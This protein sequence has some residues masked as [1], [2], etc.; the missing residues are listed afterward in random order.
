MFHLVSRW[1]SKRTLNRGKGRSQR[2]PHR[3]T[4][5]QL[6]KRD[7]L[8]AFTAG[9]LIV[10]RVGTGTGALGGNATTTFID[11]YTPAGA[12]VQSIS[13]PSTST[14]A[15]I[16]DASETGTTVTI[17]ANNSFVP[18]QAVVIAG[19][20][21]N[22][23]NGTFTITSVAANGSSFT[24]TA[25]PGLGTAMDVTSATATVSTDSL[26]E[27]GNGTTEGLLGL[28]P[29]RHSVSLAG[30]NQVP[31]GSTST[32]FAVNRVV[33]WITPDG[34]ID[35]STQLP[36]SAGS[37]RNAISATGLGFYIATSTGVLF[38]PYG[39]SGSTAP[40]LL[41][42]E[43]ASP[44]AVGIF[45]SYLTSP[46]GGWLYGSAG[47][48][49]QS[50]GVP[51]VDSP[52]IVSGSN[53]LP[54]V[55]G[56][57]I[58]NPPTS[59]PT[60]R[61]SMGNF[62]T[63]IQF[64]VSPDGNTIFI[65]DSRTDGLGGIIE[66]YQLVPGTFIRPGNF[67]IGTGA[68]S[69]LLGL[70][71]DFSNPSSPVLYAT[72]TASSGNRL[73][74]ITGGTTDGSTPTFV[75]T[76]LATAPAN[77]AIRGVSLAP[78]PA[79]ST[80][81]ATALSVGSGTGT[82]GAG[83]T[84][85]ATVTGGAGTPTGWVSFQ[86]NGVEIGAAPLNASGTATF[87]TAGNLGAAS[88]PYDVA[89][90]YTG[91]ATYA[92]SPST[93]HSVTINQA[94]ATTALTFS[95]NPVATGVNDTL[96]ATITAPVGT[97]PTGT[98]SFFDGSTLLN[99]TP[100]PVTQV[101]TNDT[102]TF[103]ASFT[104]SFSTTGSHMIRA[105]YSGDTNFTTSNDTHTLQVVNATTTT[106][107]TDNADP[108]ANPSTSFTLTAT[109]TSLGAGT[110]T[111]MV[112]FYDNLRPIGGPITVSGPSNTGAVGTVTVSTALL[113]ATGVLTPGLH[114]ISAIYTPDATSAMSY[115]TST[116][117]YEQFVQAQSFAAND[118]FVYRV[119]DGATNLIAQSPSPFA[120]SAA[121]GSTIYVDEYTPAGVLVQSIIL[122]TAAG[123]D[124]TGTPVHAVVGNGQQSTTGQMTL[125]GD[126]Q[127]LFVTGYDNNPLPVATAL[128][129]PSSTAAVNVPRSVARIKFDGTIQT[130]A[131]TAGPAASG[132]VETGGNFNGVYSPDGNQFYVSGF[133]GVSYFASF[134]PS[135][136]LVPA[137]AVI[138]NTTFTVLGLEGAGGNVAFV[139]LPYTGANL[140]GQFTGLP[141]ANTI[142]VGIS[143]LT[144]DSS[145][146]VTVTTTAA[147]GFVTGARVTI[148]GASVAGYNGTFVV[149]VTT[150]TTFTYT[151]T[152][153]GLA[154]ATGGAASEILTLPGLP[155]TD[156]F[157]QF[158]IDVYFTHLNGTG[159]P[160]GI[161][162][163]YLS[164]DGPGFANGHITKWTLGTDGNWTLTDTLTAPG[165]PSTV[166]TFYWLA[167]QTD[168]GGNVTLYSTYGNG[169]NTDTGPGFLYAISDTN[170]YGRPIGTGGTHS[171]AV[172]TVSSVSMTSNEV[173]RGV[174]LAPQ[175][176]VATHINIIV[177]DTVTAGMSFSITVQALDASNN[178]VPGYTGTVHFVASNGAMANYTFTSADM[179]QHVF[180]LTLFRAGTLGV[181]GTDTV[182]GITGMATFTVVAADPFQIALD[183]VPSSV[184]AGAPFSLTVT[185]QDAYGN[186]V[187]GYMD[188]VHFQLTGPVMPSANYTF[189]AD[190]MGSHTFDGLVLNQQGDYTLTATDP[191]LSGTLMFTVSP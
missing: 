90:V 75:A 11:E 103:V 3:L 187:T 33:G 69:G 70:F 121:I 87:V 71:A 9:D 177:Q 113:Q 176:D 49:A 97:T 96:T 168:T 101:I 120:N 167:G 85:T 141:T 118:V 104:A 84:L 182:T 145:N 88:T 62:P 124:G 158:P 130:E 53:R 189:T 48:G 44:S 100:A 117:V 165:S 185:V 163:F 23:F 122:P 94:T 92:L 191:M 13:L 150:P 2:M 111:G 14:S 142:G 143:T 17:T 184:T 28:S 162:T 47:A 170:G 52:F 57:A 135:A 45:P 106:V 102:V 129:L 157:Q 61:D 114:S 160:A 82:Y 37:V 134:A 89:A 161:N 95:A 138:D 86:Q 110:I 29:D 46:G 34:S 136:S 175:G 123:N 39:N 21:P 178:V 41:T 152:A 79:G 151:A 74:K 1:L 115:F 81:S 128:P 42:N 76:T 105:V 137:T 40:V 186:T 131:F 99:S 27:V 179:G 190:D 59:F 119:G 64:A 127:Y 58:V 174:A 188:T 180:M 77:E 43:V 15:T 16:T 22:G 172:T 60:A 98:V 6:E 35:T 65:A 55:G 31:G 116:G 93:V 146:T 4:I 20:A 25:A 32:T 166:I 63:T 8:S 7:L 68:D 181:T 91:N 153:S 155:S 54:T 140:V 66:Y 30:Y 72:T 125:S 67:Q 126:G 24:Y 26:T 112:Q 149:T 108:T 164:D 51:A 148:S 171:D 109:V 5:E 80:T 73:V 38:V 50:S 18:G 19:V 169:G 156:T 183:L 12:L 154:D 139:G 36:S 159:A 107:T 78:T 10:S 83:V 132:G 173:F 147:N 133:N 144:E 56:Q